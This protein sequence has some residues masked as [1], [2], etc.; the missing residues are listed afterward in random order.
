VELLKENGNV[1]QSSIT[2][3][4]PSCNSDSDVAEWQK[5]GYTSNVGMIA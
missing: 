2:Q 3:I 4:L 5:V 1:Q